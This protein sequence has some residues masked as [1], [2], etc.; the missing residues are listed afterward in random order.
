[1][2]QTLDLRGDTVLPGL[3]GNVELVFKDG[4]GYD[5][6]A[7]LRSAEGLVGRQ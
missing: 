1:V 7:I 4:V 2:I 3:V 5:S 6:A